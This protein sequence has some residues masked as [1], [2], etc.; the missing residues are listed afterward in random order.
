MERKW[1]VHRC[2]SFSN[3][4]ATKCFSNLLQVEQ[5]ILIFKVISDIMAPRYE[6]WNTI[7]NANCFSGK[8]MICALMCIIS[9]DYGIKCFSILLQLEPCNVMIKVI[10]DIMAHCYDFWNT[11]V[12]AINYCNAKKMIFALMFIIS[13][14]YRLKCLSNRLQLKPCNVAICEIQ[15]LLPIVSSLERK[16]YVHWCWS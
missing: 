13:C 9:N 8:K 2:L 1:F 15:L 7:V 5:C 14:H 6:M 4:Y 12:L 11:I 10:S 16:W 3:H